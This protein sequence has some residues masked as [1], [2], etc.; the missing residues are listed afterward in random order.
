MAADA[1]GQGLVPMLREALETLIASRR[2][3]AGLTERFPA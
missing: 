1:S 3:R 2:V